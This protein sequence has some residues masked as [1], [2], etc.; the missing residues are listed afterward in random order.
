MIRLLEY[1]VQILLH[2]LLLPRNDLLQRLQ[3]ILRH[4]NLAVLNLKLHKHLHQTLQTLIK[5]LV[6]RERV[7]ILNFLL[8]V[9][10]Q[11]IHVHRAG[12]ARGDLSDVIEVD[13]EVNEAGLLD[14]VELGDVEDDDGVQQ[15]EGLLVAKVH[16]DGS[17]GL[18]VEEQV[19]VQVVLIDFSLVGRGGEAE[20]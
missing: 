15:V 18:C 13:H 5:L 11:W 7:H 4:V 3:P 16:D 19:L 20:I 17:E 9:L 14:L 10:T 2:L 6:V 1:R 8:E 12:P